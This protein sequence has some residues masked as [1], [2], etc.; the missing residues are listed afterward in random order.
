MA[1]LI[2]LLAMVAFASTL[3]VSIAGAADN[4]TSPS[5]SPSADPTAYDM[6]QRFG[7]P[8]G[9]LPQG[10]QGYKL[11]DDGSSFEVYLAGD[12]EFRAAKKYVLH[13]SSRVAGQIAAGS[14][15]SLEG[16]KVKEAFAWLRIS[17]VDVD[18]D[19]IKLHVG[20]ITAIIASDQLA[21]RK[22]KK[23]NTATMAKKLLAAAAALLLLAA[24]PAL[25]SS[26]SPG[27][28]NLTATP[29]AYEMVERYGFPRGILPEGVESYVLRPD[30]SFEV[31]LSGDGDG[32][33]G[34]GDCEFRVGDGG[35]YLLRYGRRVAGVAMEGSIRSLE[36]VSVKVLFAWLGIGRVDRA[37]DDLRFFVGPL[38]AAFPLANFADCPRC[39][40]GF[41]CDTAAGAAAIAAS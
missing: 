12:C 30:G 26:S 35:A 22:S 2:F 11:A 9:I 24:A 28:S 39:R 21:L 16:V 17:E 18:G 15:T 37:G 40:C 19:Q 33:G 29:T 27:S 4:S 25:A 3:L 13:Y 38:S 10:V 23:T 20:L 34:G 32:N 7:F 41:D 14:I 8:V 31:H 36:G 5:P 1:K 6:L